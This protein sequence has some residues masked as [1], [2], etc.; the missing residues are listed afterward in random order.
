MSFIFYIL[1]FQLILKTFFTTDKSFI[2]CGMGAVSL[3]NNLSP[4]ELSLA[5]NKLKII[6]LYNESRGKDGCGW[7]INDQ[8]IKGFKID[9]QDT[10]KF[11]DFLEWNKIPTIDYAFGNISLLHCRAASHG[12]VTVENNHPFDIN[13][14]IIFQHNGTIF[15]IKELATKYNIKESSYSVDSQALGQIISTGNT[16]VLEEYNGYAALLWTDRKSLYVYK[17]SSKEKNTEEA[18]EERPMYFVETKEGI[19]F[20]SMSESL[21]AII[22]EDQQVYELKANTIFEVRNGKFTNKA[23]SITR[24][25]NPPP[26]VKYYN[27]YNNNHS[28]TPSKPK[29]VFK[30]NKPICANSQRVYFW[31]LRYW[32]PDNTLADGIHSLNK[33]GEIV[34]S[35]GDVYYFFH[36][37]MIKDKEDF[38]SARKNYES[39]FNDKKGWAWEISKLSTHPVVQFDNELTYTPVSHYAYWKGTC[40]Y[41]EDFTPKFSSGRTYKYESGDLQD[42]IPSVKN[43][44]VFGNKSTNNH[45]ELIK[46]GEWDDNIFTNKIFRSVGEF[47]KESSNEEYKALFEYC[48]EK[49]E[50][51]SIIEVTDE[52]IR[53]HVINIICSAISHK[54]T[55]SEEVNDEGGWVLGTF[56]AFCGKEDCQNDKS[57]T[58]YEGNKTVI[59]DQHGNVISKKIE[60]DNHF[61]ITYSSLYELLTTLSLYEIYTIVDF[62]IDLNKKSLLPRSNKELMDFITNSFRLLV[63]YKQTLA[64]YYTESPEYFKLISED[65]QNGITKTD[66]V[67]FKFMY[68]YITDLRNSLGNINEEISTQE[69]EEE[70]IL[71]RGL[72]LDSVKE[73]MLSVIDSIEMMIGAA[74]DLQR[75][76]EDSSQ[77]FANT[78]YRYTTNL[79]NDLIQNIDDLVKEDEEHF[80][81]E[82]N[83]LQQ[84][85]TQQ[86]VI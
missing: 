53:S 46:S 67:I 2:L 9:K 65:F 70:D 69:N 42:I 61:D 15:N 13:G 11:Q 36:G 86:N 71:D 28:S 80:K 21:W 18:K 34:G 6:G 10:K 81:D 30:E 48:K 83:K 76:D 82:R 77:Q 37:V 19:Y 55:I 5:T 31:K 68:N 16:K 73:G 66:L 78:L 72:V 8:I 85:Y 27:N 52:E 29:N 17:G 50:K 63:S 1:L 74:D 41:K 56:L 54:C 75:I 79:T 57:I 25:L 32:M 44:N 14:K 49:E 38:E 62:E 3:K 23:I 35:S 33:K 84:L 22:E 7:W 45:L 43:D 12:S 24:P 59:L 39:Y 20:S 64:E 4:A 58:V 51:D 40:N 26:V 60:E 47:F